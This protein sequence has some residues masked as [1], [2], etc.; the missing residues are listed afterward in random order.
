MEVIM[1]AMQLQAFGTGG[2]RLVERPVP[3]AGP[4]EALV[5]MKAAALNYRDLEIAAGRY[6]MPVSLPRIPLSDAVGEIVELG[7]GRKGF[8]TGEQVN[9][10]FFRTGSTA[11]F[12]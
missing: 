1:R 10:T 4:G 2:L 7:P 5:R 8:A 9:L 11:S 6:A 12:A 3:T